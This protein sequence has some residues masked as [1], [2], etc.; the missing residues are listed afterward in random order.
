MQ[1]ITFHILTCKG[2]V[3]PKWQSYAP[4]SGSKGIQKRQMRKLFYYKSF[5]FVFFV[6]V[7]QH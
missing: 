2:G 7:N 3:L 6:N 5:S 1:L 4:H